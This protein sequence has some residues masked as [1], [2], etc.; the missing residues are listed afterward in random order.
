MRALPWEFSSDPKGRAISDQFMF[1]STLLI[2]P[3]TAEGATTRTLYLPAGSAWVDFWTGKQLSGGQRITADAPLDQMPIY[4]KAGS[5]L[6][7]G[8][9][10]QFASAKSDPT[11][12]RVYGGADADF[13]LY[14][15]EG[16]NYDYEHGAYATIPVHWDNKAGRLTIG[17]RHGSFPGMLQHRTFHV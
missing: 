8:P 17:N 2:N 9:F 14:E 4:A 16:D 7:L 10:V 11:E 1:G 12:L 6:A 15:D 5:I 3:V 13:T